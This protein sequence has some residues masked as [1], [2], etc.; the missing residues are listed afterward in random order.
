MISLNKDVSYEYKDVHYDESTER[1]FIDNYENADE[2]G[3]NN[4]KNIE[5]INWTNASH[6]INGEFS[7]EINKKVLDFIKNNSNDQL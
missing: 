4:V 3:K 6:A 7:A 5:I 2:N 1:V